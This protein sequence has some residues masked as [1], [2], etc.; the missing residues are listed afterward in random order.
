M[1]AIIGAIGLIILGYRVVAIGQA[2]GFKA[3]CRA[4]SRC[5]V[6][7]GLSIG[8]AMVGGLC[9]GVTGGIAGLIAGPCVSLIISKPHF[10]R[11]KNESV[12]ET[13]QYNQWNFGETWKLSG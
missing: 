6:D 4:I 11:N 7:W 13:D 8:L 3:K 9:G 1:L 10:R 12:K 5:V 2:R